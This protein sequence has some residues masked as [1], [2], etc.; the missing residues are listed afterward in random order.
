MDD[1]SMQ[2]ARFANAREQKAG[3]AAMGHILGGITLELAAI[4]HQRRANMARSRFI[5]HAQ[6]RARTTKH[7]RP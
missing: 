1:R 4:L 6:P 3:S 7:R 5:L 2:S